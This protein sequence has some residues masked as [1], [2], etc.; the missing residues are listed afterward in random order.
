MPDQTILV[1]EDEADLRDVLR[2]HLS[3]LGY[4]VVTAESAETALGAVEVAPPDLV[5]T[6][7]NMGAMSGLELTARLKRDHR[8]QLTPVVLLTSQSDLDARVAGLEAG[9]DD[10]FSKPVELLELRTRVDTLLRVKALVDQ[11]ERAALLVTTL[12]ATIESRDPYTGG[13]CERLG[14]YGVALGQALGADEATIEALRLGGFLHDLGKIAVPDGILLK[15]GRLEAAERERIQ[16]HSAVGADLVR[17]LRTLDSVRPIIRHHHE[18]WGGSGYPDG[19]RGDSIP[20]GARIMA[21]VD[22]YDA[23]RTARPYKPSFSETQTVEILRR[24][25]DAGAWDPRVTDTFVEAL[26]HGLTREP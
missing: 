21:V 2:E 7:V 19:L 16:T 15:A 22:V 4:R 14:R 10:F 24:E 25:T 1:V 23:L 20:F 12:G 8:S 18:R 11:L 17:G 6:D 26:R 9:A 3:A 5:L 13:H